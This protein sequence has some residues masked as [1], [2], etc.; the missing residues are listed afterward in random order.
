MLIVFL[1]FGIIYLGIY[2]VAINQPIKHTVNLYIFC[3]TGVPR[4]ASIRASRFLDKPVAVLVIPKY[5]LLDCLNS[6]GKSLGIEGGSAGEAIDFM[7]QSGLAN[8][9]SPKELVQ[10]ASSMMRKTLFRG[11]LLFIKG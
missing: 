2:C 9:I 5:S 4:L 1:F 10:A 6:K 3:T 8:K 7:R 11:D